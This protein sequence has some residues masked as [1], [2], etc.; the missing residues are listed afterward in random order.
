MSQNKNLLQLHYYACSLEIERWD[1]SA[2][3]ELKDLRIGGDGYVAPYFTVSPTHKAK[4]WLLDPRAPKVEPPLAV[5]LLKE[6][7]M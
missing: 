3:P 5:K 2:N 7:G 1:L 6:E 4:T